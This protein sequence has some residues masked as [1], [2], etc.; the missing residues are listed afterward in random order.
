MYILRLATEVDW[1]NESD[2]FQSFARETAKFYRIQRNNDLL[3]VRTFLR[4][5]LV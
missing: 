5:S 3:K 1:D 2:C 4:L